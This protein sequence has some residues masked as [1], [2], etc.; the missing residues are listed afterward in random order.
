MYLHYQVFRVECVCFSF[1]I[2]IHS[3]LLLWLEWRGTHAGGCGCLTWPLFDAPW[4]IGGVAAYICQGQLMNAGVRLAG[5]PKTPL[6]LINYPEN[7]LKDR[8]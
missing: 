4:C 1:P 5:S 6:G 8:I 2:L 3:L 7:T